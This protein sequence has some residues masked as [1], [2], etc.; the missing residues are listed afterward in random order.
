MNREWHSGAL[1][2]WQ[3]QAEPTQGTLSITY[4]SFV[5]NTLT[6]PYRIGFETIRAG[7]LPAADAYATEAQTTALLRRGAD[8]R[9]QRIGASDMVSTEE[10]ADMSGTSRVTV[11]AWIKSGRCIGVAHLRRGF[12][13]PK[14]QFEP[15]IFPVIQPLFESLGTTDGWQLLSFLE[16]P[17]PALGDL[18]PRTALE[19]GISA[20]T[21]V[22]LAIAEGH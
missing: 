8:Y 4:I 9:R 7:G 15:Y 12:K 11:N 20:K 10:G 22:E 21:I 3:P 14:W 5:M 6:H 19:R 18:T 16:T 1:F 2:H 17:H 13:M